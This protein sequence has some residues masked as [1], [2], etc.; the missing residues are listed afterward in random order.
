[1]KSENKKSV[2]DNY[3][4][5]TEFNEYI[6]ETIR[7]KHGVSDFLARLLYAQN[8]DLEQIEHFLTPSLKEY[9][10]DPFHLIDMDKA[11][12]RVIQAINQQEHICILG[13]YDVDGATSAALLKNYFC[14]LEI[15]PTIYIPER[16][17][18]G[19]GPSVS[20]MKKLKSANVNLIITVDCGTSAYEALAEAKKQCIDVIVIDHHLSVEQ[21]PNAVAIVNPNRLDETSTYNYLAAVGV[22][23]LFLIA[24]RSV[25][26]KQQYFINKS[27]PSL[28]KYLDLVALGTVCD[29]MALVGL[30][31]A[32]VSKGLEV[33][34]QQQNIGIKALSY[35]SEAKFSSDCYYLGFVL[36]PRINAGGRIGKSYLGSKLLSTKCQIE[37]YNIASELESYNSERK[38]IEKIMLEEAVSIALEQTS[39]NIIVV[40]KNNW[41]PGVIGIIASRLKDLFQKPTV[42][43]SLNN[44]IGHASC[45]SIKGIDIGSKIAEAKLQGLLI[46]GGGHAMAAGFTIERHLI[47]DL[48]N[49]LN[50]K[51]ALAIQ[52][53]TSCNTKNYVIDLSL[54]SLNINTVHEIQKL[55]PFGNGNPEPIFKLTSIKLKYV[56]SLS[57][58][59]VHC[60]LSEWGNINTVK[61]TKAIA[62]NPRAQLF[63]ALL[64]SYTEPVDLIGNIKVNYWHGRE[65]VQFVIKDLIT[66]I[67]NNTR[68]NS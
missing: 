32:F 23:F 19:Y 25:L 48:K 17:T 39:N 66:G 65:E 45:R 44:N 60:T 28:I 37:A 29:V 6:I 5:K 49:F 61:T 8:I 68:Y 3:W 35:L 24:L 42:V 18:E 14:E 58:K 12:N 9:L 11:V 47:N 1:M 50:Q 20:A 40:A 59:Y 53:L 64:N 27:E 36:G 51:L 52:N 63:D 62:F 26:R 10:P 7:Q 56:N 22:S 15:E 46:T 38:L 2:L 54:A 16:L 4:N 55:A 34:A 43:I 67:N 41:H 57:N 21:L 31:R 13:D 30:N 33:I